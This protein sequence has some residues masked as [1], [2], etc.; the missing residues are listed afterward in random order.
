ML[1]AA[2][3]ATVA[4]V[5]ATTTSARSR[6]HKPPAPATSASPATATATL[7]LKLLGRLGG[8]GNVVFSPDSIATAVA[9]AGTGARGATAT[10]IAR[11]LALSSP[12]AFTAVGRLQH[13]IS[14]EQ[15]GAANSDPQA[16]T[17][18]LANALFLQQGF[19]LSSSF[20]GTLQR[21][22]GAAP[23][24]V[25]FSGNAPAAVAAINGYV[26]QHTQGVIPKVI[27]SV[28]AGTVLALVNAI[29]LKA[30][31]ANPFSDSATASAS[32]HAPTGTVSVPFMKETDELPYS[33]GSGYA[34]VELP[35]RSSTLSLMVVLPV[36][37]SIGRLQS[38]LTAGKLAAIAHGA[39]GASVQ[40]SLPRFHL[41][42]QAM[43]NS[44]LQALGM[45]LAFSD[46]AN[47]SGIHAPPP[48]LKIG[49]VVHAADFTIDEHGTIA[50]ASTVVTIEPTAIAVP[51]HPVAFDAN[52]PFLFFLRDDTTGAVLFAGRVS[53]PAT[54]PAS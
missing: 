32:F 43:L 34:A 21:A 29:Y 48:K 51:Q 23:Q 31:W 35:Y 53:D 6:P 28:P 49:E 17:L 9:M 24:T 52:R 40:L 54:A 7:G 19:A 36:G 41:S 39:R 15:Q 4:L 8:S 27:G 50:A 25:D 5:L 14:A 47:F 42:Y 22:F 45:T 11:T 20:T 18:D 30:A 12:S 10:G 2:V 1:A 3:L 26:D 37:Q 38:S 13:A 44:T 16:P 46:A 33:S